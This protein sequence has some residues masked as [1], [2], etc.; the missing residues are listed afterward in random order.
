MRRKPRCYICH[1]RLGVFI[2]PS[3]LTGKKNRHYICM[4]CY[5]KLKKAREQK[6][7]QRGKFIAPDWKNLD[8]LEREAE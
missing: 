6:E 3:T 7:T 4:E 5:E 1:K 8:K 2:Y